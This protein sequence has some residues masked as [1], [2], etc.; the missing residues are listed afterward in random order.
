M[1]ED[2]EVSHIPFRTWFAA[3][4]RGRVKKHFHQKIRDMPESITIFHVDYVRFALPGE[5]RTE[6]VSG[7]DL[8]ALVAYDRKKGWWMIIP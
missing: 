1:I 3:W 2:H 4:A 6:I 7:K 8:P 5:T